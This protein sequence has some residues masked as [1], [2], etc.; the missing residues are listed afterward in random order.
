MYIYVYM[1]VGGLGV[2]EDA[3]SI[4]LASELGPSS[5]AS[6]AQTPQTFVRLMV[7]NTPIRL[8]YLLEMNPSKVKYSALFIINFW[9]G[10][11]CY[12]DL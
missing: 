12:A 8:F 11:V 10:G 7:Y 1:T 5:Q 4:E 6:F 2:T 3:S 9:A